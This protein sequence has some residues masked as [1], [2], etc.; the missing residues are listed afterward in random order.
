MPKEITDAMRIEITI[1]TF[2]SPPNFIKTPKLVGAIF[3]YKLVQL[4]VGRMQSG[5]D[6]E[7]DRRDQDQAAHP[8]TDP[9]ERHGR[10]MLHSDLL[11]GESESPDRGA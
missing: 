4:P 11:G 1:S 9:V 2:Y 6:T 5:Q 8:E 3:K 7:Q 10:K